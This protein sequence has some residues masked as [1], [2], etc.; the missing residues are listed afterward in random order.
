M[1]SAVSVVTAP[2]ASAQSTTN[3][4]LTF[5]NYSELLREP[6]GSVIIYDGADGAAATA[7]MTK[8]DLTSQITGTSMGY[9]YYSAAIMWTVPLPM[10]LHV[11]GT[12]T[13]RAYISSSYQLSGLFSG[14]GYSF[15]VVDVDENNREVKEFLSS[16]T[17]NLGNP[18][19]STPTQYSQSVS[20]DYTFSKGHTLAFVVG[21]GATSQGFT[22]S[23]YFGSADRA[24]GATLPVVQ[25]T[26]T[27]SVQ[28]DAGA[29]T[30][31]SDAAISNLQYD[32][33]NHAITYN[34]KGIDYTPCSCTVTVPK[35]LMQAPFTVTQGIK[36]LQVTT[37]QNEANTIITYSH[38]IDDS[39]L[40]VTGTSST[41]NTPTPTSQA[42]T[43]TSSS[44]PTSSSSTSAS[45]SNS[46]TANPSQSTSEPTGSASPS[47]SA[48]QSSSS[49]PH[50]NSPPVPEWSIYVLTILLILSAAVL[51]VVF[52]RRK[53]YFI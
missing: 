14:G 21:L 7:S 42:P 45:P 53:R 29:V 17:Y 30:V 19:T 39:Q 37:S 50:T 13:I 31:S 33:N 47:S 5:H 12:V 24:S 3:L 11:K 2:Q 10:D 43:P 22:A 26:Q 49:D 48:Q 41:T 52:L 4:S 1:F 36:T 34:A 40:K 27:Q 20:V 35:A 23:V 28:T 9:S 18:F 32:K 25:S 8:A 15:G 51:S 16:A 44:N 38:S 6:N 46:V